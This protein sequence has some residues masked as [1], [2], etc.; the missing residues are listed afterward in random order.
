MSRPARITILCEDLQH[1][2]FVRRFLMNRG[3]T[4][5]DIREQIHSAGR[6]SAQQGVRD[7]FPTEL[8]AYR[9]KCNYLRNGLIAVIDADVRDVRDRVRNFDTA[10]DE[11]GVRR[12]QVDERVLLV[13]PK[14]NIE[15]WLAYLRGESVNETDQYRRYEYES[16]CHGDVDQLDEMCKRGELTG[17]A[18][19]SLQECCDDFERFWPLIQTG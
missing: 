18:P 10:C 14:R 16:R 12:R 7:R 15:T 2:C 19:P 13:I 17:S 9:S 11:Q 5:H 3:W 6:G 1:A 4:R 8:R